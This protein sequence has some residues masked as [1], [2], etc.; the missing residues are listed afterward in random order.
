MSRGKSADRDA[1]LGAHAWAYMR[2]NPHYCTA[3][4]ALAVP[5]LFERADMPIR[6]QT[7]ADLLAEGEWGLLVWEDPGAEAWRSP[8]WSG[9]PMLIGEPDPDPLGSFVPM[10]E[11]GGGTSSPGRPTAAPLTAGPLL[12]AER[13]RMAETTAGS[14][15]AAGWGLADGERGGTGVQQADAEVV[16]GG[17]REDRG[18]T[19]APGGC[20]VRWR[21]D[22]PHWTGARRP[23]MQRGR[24][25]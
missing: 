3:W 16:G 2:R 5:P 4:A 20:S 21:R 23:A 10:R 1:V 15:V 25:A 9:I 6:V 18:L 13:T 19:P 12:L 14:A 8:F 24:S 7:E 11:N 17:E 22:R